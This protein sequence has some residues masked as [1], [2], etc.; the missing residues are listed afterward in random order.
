MTDREIIIHLAEK[1]M[2]WRN[3]DT[4]FS[5]QFPAYRDMAQ[6]DSDDLYRVFDR[7]K[8]TGRNWNPLISITDA[9]EVQA[10]LKAGQSPRYMDAL[11]NQYLAY[12][13]DCSWLSYLICAT[14]R[15][16]C[17]AIVEATK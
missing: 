4:D 5:A 12:P 8:H 14:P 17:L 13:E 2:G 9:F 16:R 3:C 15:Q 11:E 6:F 7:E 10:A 1:V